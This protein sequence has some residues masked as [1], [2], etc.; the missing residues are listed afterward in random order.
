[1]KPGSKIKN[2]AREPERIPVIQKVEMMRRRK[3][4]WMREKLKEITLEKGVGPDPRK[5]ALKLLPVQRV[6]DLFEK[7]RGGWSSDRICEEFGLKKPSFD[8]YRIKERSGKWKGFGSTGQKSLIVEEP[9]EPGQIPSL[10]TAFE[11]SLPGMGSLGFGVWGSNPSSDLSK[12]DQETNYWLGPLG[13]KRLTEIS[14][15]REDFGKKGEKRGRK[16]GLMWKL[17]EEVVSIGEGYTE[18]LVNR[19]IEQDSLKTHRI[20]QTV[21]GRE[22]RHLMKAI[23]T[24]MEEGNVGALGAGSPEP[25]RSKAGGTTERDV[26][27]YKR[28][29]KEVVEWFRLASARFGISVEL[30]DED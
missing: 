8:L 5:P 18:E 27:D 11:S 28:I 2:E 13:L 25:S 21:L 19:G 22:I 3:E 29:T 12:I 16:V 7:S 4:D 9:T 1:M 10:K 26:T 17:F 20:I 24:A 30:C 6:G 14:R 23:Q 15:E